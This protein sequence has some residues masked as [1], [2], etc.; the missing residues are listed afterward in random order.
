MPGKALNPAVY[1]FSGIF[2]NGSAKTAVLCAAV[3]RRIKAV[4]I[5]GASGTAKTVLARSVTNVDP[6]RKVVNVPLNVTDEQLFGA[7]D[8]E[9]AI[10][11]GQVVLGDSLLRRADGNYLYLDDADLFDPRSLTAL[12]DTALDG[13]VNIEREN[14]SASYRCNTTVFASI[15]SSRKHIDPHVLDCF[16]ICVTMRPPAETSGRE[17]II[18]RNLFFQEGNFPEDR[19]F[20]GQDAGYADKV[21]RARKLLPQVR[22]PKVRLR[23]I[24]RLCRELGVKG[25]RGAIA[26]GETAMAIAALEGRKRVTSQD[27]ARAALLCLDHRRVQHVKRREKKLYTA[28]GTGESAIKR[29]IH[30]NRRLEEAK[31]ADDAEVSPDS[32]VPMDMMPQNTKAVEIGDV[33]SKVGDTFEAID[34]LEMEGGQFY[35]GDEVAKRS[36]RISKDRNGQ[37]IKSRMTEDKNPDIAFDATVRAAAPYQL[38]RRKP[39]ETG[40]RLEKQDLREKVREKHVSSTFLFLLDNSGSL[41]IRNRMAAVKAA[42]ISMLSTHYV[43]RDRVGLMTFNEEN[44]D[45]VLQPTR[46]IEQL[47]DIIDRLSVGQGTPLSEALIK[48]NEYMVPYTLKHPDEQC[49]IVLITDGKATVA[50]DPGADPVK[51]AL[52]IAENMSIPGTDWIVIDSGL[53]FTKNEVPEELAKALR[54]RFFLLDDLKAEEKAKDVWS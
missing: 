11:T 33:V 13:N 6:G 8:L 43:K 34:L 46:A 45:L 17:E 35:S 30:D 48:V 4:L 39:G 38:R 16:D 47:N 2:G 20:T 37:Y 15:N 51:E 22:M 9:A 44:I 1:P 36:Y 23:E 24:A 7:I 42:I 49:H 21:K 18:R 27:A 50:M 32:V 31:P 25:C 52:H 14:I 3:N 28:L 10:D 5:R 53:G 12:M 26:T 40:V 54:G 29:A 41:I 19:D